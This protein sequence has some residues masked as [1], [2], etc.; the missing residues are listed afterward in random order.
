MV[1]MF[2]LTQNLCK[3]CNMG[4]CIKVA[5]DYVSPQNVRR[6][7]RLTAE[8]RKQNHSEAWKEDVLQLRTMMWYAWLS[9]DKLRASLFS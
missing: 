3:V 9:C 4:D 8:F 7:E 2:I 6:C 1:V 5:V